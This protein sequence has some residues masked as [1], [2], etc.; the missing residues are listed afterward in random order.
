MEEEEEEEEDGGLFFNCFVK[1]PDHN[2]LLISSMISIIL[3][4]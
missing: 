2:R 3:K 4:V 1:A